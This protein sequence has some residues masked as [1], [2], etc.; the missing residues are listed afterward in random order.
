MTEQEIDATKLLT[1]QDA[2]R[3][4]IGTYRAPK[5]AGE[6][7]E[8][9]GI[10]IATCFRIINNLRRMGLLEVEK[11]LYNEDKRVDYFSAT[12]ENAYVFYDSGR[13]KVRFKVVLQMASDF[14]NRYETFLQSEYKGRANIINIDNQK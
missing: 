7:S 12:L 5:S 4:L 9:Y 3:I 2:T 10:P 6:L 14:R 13:L 11:T 1:D 8:I